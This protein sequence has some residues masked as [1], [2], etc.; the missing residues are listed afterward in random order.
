MTESPIR[1]DSLLIYQIAIFLI[2]LIWT[3]IGIE[4]AQYQL[5]LLYESPLTWVIWS[6]FVFTSFIPVA[7]GLAWR[8]KTQVRFS[9]PDWD[10]REREISLA[11]YRDMIKQYVREY[12]NFLSIIDYGLIL[13][14]C[15]VS[16]SAVGFPFLLMRM[17]VLVIA[18]TPMIFGFLVLLFGIIWS[19]FMFKFI[20]ND[21][22]SCFSIVPTKS[23]SHIIE[24]MEGTPGISW[25]GVS[26]TLGE[27]FGYFIVQDA[28]PVSRIEGI[29]SVAKIRGIVGESGH[30]SKLLSTLELD[31]EEES[32]IVV[33][34]SGEFTTRV[35]A[36]TVLKTLQNYLEAKGTDEFIEEVVEEVT[37]FMKHFNGDSS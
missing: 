6:V 13:F 19:S 3:F 2:V 14:A 31:N 20:P 28:S 7:T 30:V 15:V 5:P 29:E 18:I 17:S 37:A 23:L 12:R 24:M 25:V 4:V 34:I 22:T 11:E 8:M 35:I 36:N 21:A 33:E 10:I 27:A 9:Q 32:Q 1:T 16:A 26:V